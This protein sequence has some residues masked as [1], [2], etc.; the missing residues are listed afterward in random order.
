MSDLLKKNLTCFLLLW[1]NLAHISPLKCVGLEQVSWSKVNVIVDVLWNSFPGVLLWHWSYLAYLA[2][3][4]HNQ[5]VVVIDCAVTWNLGPRP[6]IKV[7]TDF[8]NIIVQRILSFLLAI[9]V[10][11]FPPLQ[12]SDCWTNEVK[13]FFFKIIVLSKSM[14][15]YECF[16]LNRDLWDDYHLTGV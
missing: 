15:F 7:I 11:F 13:I 3:A 12:L 6:K 4:S 10:I 9:S 8:C 2:H 16:Y 14:V 1:T 5:S